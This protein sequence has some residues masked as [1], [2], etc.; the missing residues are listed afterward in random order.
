VPDSS[1]L[2]ILKIKLNFSPCKA[3]YIQTEFQ[4]F[5]IFTVAADPELMEVMSNL[6]PALG[7]QITIT[8]CHIQHVYAASISRIR[9]KYVTFRIF[10]RNT[11][12]LPFCAERILYDEVIH[13]FLLHQGER[14][15]TYQVDLEMHA[16]SPIIHDLTPLLRALSS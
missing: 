11:D 6:I 8:I 5:A 12:S 16:A 2:R 4:L 14:Q 9:V 10:V 1:L 13:A 15:K 7:N 3:D